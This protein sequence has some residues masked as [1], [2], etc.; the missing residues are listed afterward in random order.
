MSASF[1]TPGDQTKALISITWVIRGY[2]NLKNDLR[3][4]NKPKEGLQSAKK[5][6]HEAAD[7]A[8]MINDV[9]S[10]AQFVRENSG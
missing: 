5:K 3:S 9:A 4:Q 10:R 8:I 1:K 2:F 7:D 6:S